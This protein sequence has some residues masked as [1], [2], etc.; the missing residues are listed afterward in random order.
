MPGFVFPAGK[1]MNSEQEMP[2]HVSYPV[3]LG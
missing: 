1:A 2:E 3:R